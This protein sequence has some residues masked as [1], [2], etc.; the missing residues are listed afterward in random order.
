MRRCLYINLKNMEMVFEIVH[1]KN[2]IKNAEKNY[3][4]S[5]CATEKIAWAGIRVAQE[6]VLLPS[7]MDQHYKENC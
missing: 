6:R 1:V 4:F 3:L 7:H 5:F 2:L